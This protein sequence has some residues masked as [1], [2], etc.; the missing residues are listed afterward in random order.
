MKNI[1]IGTLFA[2]VSFPCLAGTVKLDNMSQK[3]MGKDDMGTP[4]VEIDGK[5][6]QA[7]VRF[8][9][10]HDYDGDLSPDTSAKLTVSGAKG[11]LSSG[12]G[13]ED[14]FLDEANELVCVATPKGPMLVL[15]AWCTAN[16]CPEVNYQVVDASS[17]RR[18]TKYDYDNACNRA[19]AENALG[20]KLPVE[21]QSF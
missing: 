9:G 8:S 18:L 11:H 19:C 10:I 13:D 15:A 21:L 1:L 7:S 17:I 2:I 20:T 12:D 16:S 6:G 14:L 3:S 5:C 4:L